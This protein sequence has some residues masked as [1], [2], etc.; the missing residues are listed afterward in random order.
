MDQRLWVLG[1]TSGIGAAT[2]DLLANCGRF[3][4]THPT[5]SEQADV[6]ELAY[7]RAYIEEHGPFTHVVYSVGINQLRWI[8]DYT[9]PDELLMKIMDVNVGGFVRTMAALEAENMGVPVRLVAVSSDAATRPMRTSVAYCASKA[10]LDMAVRVAARELGPLGW[11]VNAVAPGMTEPTEMQAYID[12][13]VPQIRNWSLAKALSYEASQNPL[14]R[15]A[16]VDEIAEVIG[17]VLFAP[18]YLNGSII[19]VNGGR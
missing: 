12:R 6:R 1:G 10:A 18:D 11:R 8:K 17:D 16:N 14:G 15:R 13:A 3:E 4:E 9:N 2:A 7:L 19:T 5:D